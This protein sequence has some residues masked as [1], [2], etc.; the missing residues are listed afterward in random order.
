MIC[1]YY[2]LKLRQPVLSDLWWCTKNQYS[3]SNMNHKCLFNGNYALSSGNHIAVKIS[4]NR[5]LNDSNI[6]VRRLPK[7]QHN[8]PHSFK[9]KFRKPQMLF[10]C[11]SKII[12]AKSGQQWLRNYFLK[13]PLNCQLIYNAYSIEPT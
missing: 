2:N 3:M 13:T 7:H 11:I 10:I 6:S 9:I 5:N 1:L 4:L 8:H 12:L